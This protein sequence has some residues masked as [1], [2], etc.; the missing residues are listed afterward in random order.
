MSYRKELVNRPFYYC[1][2]EADP[3]NA[4]II[5]SNAN[6]FMIS[7]DAGKTWKIMRT[8]HGD[9]HDIWINPNNTN[10]WIQSNDGGANITFN[11]GKSWTTQF[12]S[13]I[14]I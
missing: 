9:N 6:R 12:L 7:S 4:D 11:G 8:P 1:N 10:I 5:F 13:L 2:L 3:K 14:H